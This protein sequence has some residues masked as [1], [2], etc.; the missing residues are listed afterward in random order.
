MEQIRK[1]N[2]YIKKILSGGDE[3]ELN[4]RWNLL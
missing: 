1:Y 4:D 3:F 2:S